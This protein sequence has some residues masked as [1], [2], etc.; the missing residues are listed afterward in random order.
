M[1]MVR[2]LTQTHTHPDTHTYTH[3]YTHTHTVEGWAHAESKET[4]DEE[5][6]SWRPTPLQWLAS[7]TRGRYKYEDIYTFTVMS[8]QIKQAQSDYSHLPNA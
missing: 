8:L 6:P 4:Q 2:L 5:T 3:T 1:V 7:C